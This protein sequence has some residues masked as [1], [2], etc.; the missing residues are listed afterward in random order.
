MTHTPHKVAQHPIRMKTVL[1]LEIVDCHLP[2]DTY[3]IH[4]R[5]RCWWIAL[6]NSHWSCAFSFSTG[7]FIRQ[8]AMIVFVS[9]DCFT[10]AKTQMSWSIGRSLSSLWTGAG[11]YSS[12]HQNKRRIL[13][14]LLK[15]CVW[16]AMGSCVCEGLLHFGSTERLASQWW[17][18]NKPRP[19]WLVR[20][21]GPAWPPSLSPGECCG[22]LLLFAIAPPSFQQSFFF[23]P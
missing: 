22:A 16:A 13:K 5:P 15:M 9:F 11:V 10:L 14:Q 17:R 4:S 18:I 19:G 3:P 2:N 8:Q 6:K 20:P 21:A 23:F 7:G 1:K 12:Q